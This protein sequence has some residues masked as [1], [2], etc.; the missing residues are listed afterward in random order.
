MQLDAIVLTDR[1]SFQASFKRT[2]AL[3]M[4]LAQYHLSSWETYVV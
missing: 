2:L 4:Q 3:W 1:I